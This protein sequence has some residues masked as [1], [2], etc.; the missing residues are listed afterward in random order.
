MKKSP[1]LL[2]N[3]AAM[4]IVLVLLGLAINYGIHA[5]THHGESVVMPSIRG[6]S[7]TEAR[8]MLDDIGLEIEVTDTG[9]VKNQPS[10]SVLQQQPEAGKR[11]KTGH[12]VT[13]TINSLNSPTISLP[14]LV[15]NSSLR[16]ATVK[17]KAMGFK[18]D[19]P[20]YIKGEKDWVY[21]ITCGGKELMAGDKVSI[22]RAITIV[23]G[24][25]YA[26]EQDDDIY[27]ETTADSTYVPVKPETQDEDS[28]MI[29]IENFPGRTQ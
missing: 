17:L 2:R 28:E 8:K 23:V 15:D 26:D 7:L 1:G 9:Y 10:E 13:V 6:K 5:Y 25:G 29:D 4:A 21:A 16:E 11:I 12:I 14:D 24:D 3:L 19:P 18:L 22:D 20:R 27:Y